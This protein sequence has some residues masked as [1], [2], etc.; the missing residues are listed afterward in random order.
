M[1]PPPRVTPVSQAPAGIEDV[2]V[3]GRF[4]KVLNVTA[5]LARSPQLTRHFHALGGYFVASSL[6]PA[7]ARELVIL[8]MAWL[9]RCEYEFGVHVVLGR[10]AGLSDAEIAALAGQLVDEHWAAPDLALLRMT[11]ELWAADSIT[12]RTWHDLAVTWSPAGLVDLVVLA[13]FFRMSDAF[14]NALRVQPEAGMPDSFLPGQPA[15]DH[16]DAAKT[17]T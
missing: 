2:F 12:D 5:T 1:I 9:T 7:R 16:V 15:G 17:G 13:G 3:S 8:R 6:V 14:L 4:G 11:D 10:Q